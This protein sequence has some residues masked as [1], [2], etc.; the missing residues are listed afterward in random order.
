MTTLLKGNIFCIL[1]DLI[2]LLIFHN[3]PFD[4]CEIKANFNTD[5]PS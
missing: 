2:F 5:Y 3:Q 4:L 1:H